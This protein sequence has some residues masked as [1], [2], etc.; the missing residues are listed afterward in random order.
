MRE[1]DDLILI[2][3][4][5]HIIEPPD[6]FDGPPPRPVPGPSPQARAQ[7]GRH[8]RLAVRHDACRTSPSTPWPGAPGGVRGRAQSLDEVRPG[9]YDVH[10]R[11]KDMNAGGVLASMYFPSFPG[12]TARLFATDDA[13]LSLGPRAG[14][15]RLAHRRVVRRL[16]RPVHPDGAAG[17]LGRRADAPTRSAGWPPRAATR[18]PSPRTRRPSATR[19][20]TTTTGTRCGGR[21][22]TPGRCSPSTSARR[23]SSRSRRPTRRPT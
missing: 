6:L 9:C 21:C 16:P 19:A 5:D 3:V 18:S 7:R 22:A 2:S 11:V 1:V 20:S 15:Q 10:E 14:L 17:H 12:F 23:A 4:D 13:E 8:R